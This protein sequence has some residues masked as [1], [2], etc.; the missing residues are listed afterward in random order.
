MDPCLLCDPRSEP[1][2][3]DA[4]PI[5]TRHR[6]QARAAF[7]A[8]EPLL[9]AHLEQTYGAELDGWAQRGLLPGLTWHLSLREPSTIRE[10]SGTPRPGRLVR[11]SRAPE[12]FVQ[13]LREFLVRSLQQASPEQGEGALRVGT[14]DGRRT[15]AVEPEITSQA[16]RDLVAQIV[17][18]DRIEAA[19]RSL[20]IERAARAIIEASLEGRTEPDELVSKLEVLSTGAQ[21]LALVRR[22]VVGESML[23]DPVE[24]ADQARVGSGE[25]A[26]GWWAIR[27]G[28][29]E[30]AR[31]WIELL[32]GRFPRARQPRPLT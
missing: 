19:L 28:L 27:A 7:E 21:T 10:P 9:R 17:T 20:P 18:L 4:A 5:C 2:G 32:E 1:R 31:Q 6:Q 15:A 16:L 30:P 23:V 12:A 3:T 29:A 13:L 8:A 22:M 25:F 26:R 24:V 11:L 14:P